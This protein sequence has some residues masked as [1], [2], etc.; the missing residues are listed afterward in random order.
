MGI[1]PALAACRSNQARIARVSWP[2]FLLGKRAEREDVAVEEV[3]MKIAPDL[4]SKWML[5][6]LARHDTAALVDFPEQASFGTSAEGPAEFLH[7]LSPSKTFTVRLQWDGGQI[8]RE[9]E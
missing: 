6:H 5:V 8:V 3:A 7:V 9:S 2:P 4:A 1:N